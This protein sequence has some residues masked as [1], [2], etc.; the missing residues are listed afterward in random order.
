MSTMHVRMLLLVPLILAMGCG[1]GLR[2]ELSMVPGTC[3]F[4]VH[5]EQGLSPLV[6]AELVSLDRNL[7]LAES[8]LTRGPVGVTLMGVDI[9]TLSPQFLFLSRKVSSERAASLTSDL[10]N[11]NRR[12]EGTRTDLVDR[13]GIIRASVTRRSGWTAV[14][15]GPAANITMEAWLRMEKVGSLAA[16]QALIEALPG[17]HHATLLLPGN[18]F[19]FVSLLPVERYIPWWSTYTG[20]ARTVR[21]SALALSLSWPSSGTVSLEARMA[22]E[23]GGLTAAELTLSDTGISPD[24]LFIILSNMAGGLF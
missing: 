19:A 6:M 9:T 10:L 16:D 7:V 5:L 12:D 23:D 15:M 11:L 18:L 2:D 17:K 24:S 4:H 8:L 21:P 20:L 14:Y 13:G 3:L 22:R 1:G